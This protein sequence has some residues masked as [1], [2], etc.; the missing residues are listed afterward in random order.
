VNSTA[1][2]LVD[3][4]ICVI[5]YL[6]VQIAQSAQHFA[7]LVSIN[8]TVYVKLVKPDAQYPILRHQLIF[9]LQL[10]LQYRLGIGDSNLTALESC[11]VY[12][13]FFIFPPLFSTYFSPTTFQNPAAVP[14][15]SNDDQAI[16]AEVTVEACKY[17]ASFDCEKTCGLCD[18]CT[19]TSTRAECST[20][21]KLGREKCTKFCKSGQ[22]RCLT[23]F[24]NFF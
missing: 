8:V 5:L 11:V 14:E 4:A 17:Y 2:K 16:G 13:L 21:C 6:E 22:D 24:A 10:F 19:P 12:L 23:F 1:K 7:I 3:S 18:L 20:L 15:I 9:E